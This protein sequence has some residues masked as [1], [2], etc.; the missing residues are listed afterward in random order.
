MSRLESYKNLKPSLLD[1]F[2]D[3]SFEG[4]GRLGEVDIQQMTVAVRR[5]L[6]ELLNTRAPQID[7]PEEFKEVRNSVVAY[8]M[9]DLTSLTILAERRGVAVG[10]ILQEIIT[11][12]EPRLRDVKA[13]QTEGDD[14]KGE[15]R[16][17]FHIEAR[18]RVEPYPS[19][20]FETVLELATGHASVSSGET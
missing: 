9:P 14:K 4:A 11:R 3:P 13:I 1:R 7:L 12:F 17:R 15:L 5:D 10:T 6:E 19:V 2:L 16:M 20:S 18:L 8:G